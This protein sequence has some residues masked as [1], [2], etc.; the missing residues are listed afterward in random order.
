[1]PLSTTTI[2][3]PSTISQNGEW[4]FGTDGRVAIR[5]EPRL[6]TNSVDAAIDA[7]LAG[8]ASPAPCPYQVERHVE[9]DV[10]FPCCEHDPPRVPVSLVFQANRA[11][12]AN[13]AFV[14]AMRPPPG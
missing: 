6:L 10:W 14:E 7:A 13:G 2:S 4:R 5:F 12:S 11:R 1:L 8:A 3:S 9:A